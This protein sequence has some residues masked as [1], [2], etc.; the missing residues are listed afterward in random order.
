LPNL[1]SRSGLT[2]LQ[3]TALEAPAAPDDITLR[4]AWEWLGG[5]LKLILFRR[6]SGRSDVI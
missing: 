3:V 6:Y 5:D 4:G 1:F 2:R